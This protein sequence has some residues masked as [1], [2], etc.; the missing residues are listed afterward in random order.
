MSFSIPENVFEGW[1]IVLIDDEPDS[2]EVAAYVLNFY[3]AEVHVAENGAEG[4][5]LIREKR[6]YF[7]I[8]D[9]SMPVMDGWQLVRELQEDPATRDLTI[10]ALTS[11]AMVGDREKALAAG[12]TYYLTKPFQV[13]T[14]ITDV[15]LILTDIPALKERL[16]IE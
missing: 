16:H 9:L 6:P 13:D 3:G 15:M 4:L 2:L 7:V 1:T 10:I 11:H 12:F 5:K 14:F 8:S